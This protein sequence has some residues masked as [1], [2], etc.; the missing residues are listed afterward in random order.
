MKSSLHPVRAAYLCEPARCLS[1]ALASGFVNDVQFSFPG[2]VTPLSV[3]KVGNRT[4]IKRFCVSSD[5][6]HAIYKILKE[7]IKTF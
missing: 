6:R 5:G 7:Q 2:S 3:C 1:P 4:K